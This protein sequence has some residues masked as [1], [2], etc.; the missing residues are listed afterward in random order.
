[1][2][3]TRGAFWVV[4]YPNT[5]AEFIHRAES[6]YDCTLVETPVVDPRGNTLIRYLVREEE[7]NEILAFLPKIPDDI[8]LPPETL[9]SL[10]VVLG[11]DPTDFE[12]P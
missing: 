11:I 2:E 12:L 8:G 9:R 7:G 5:L 10:C 6:R 4:S 3:G 1:M